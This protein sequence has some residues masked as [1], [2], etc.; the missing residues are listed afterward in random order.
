MRSAPQLLS[1]SAPSAPQLL[2]L[3][4]SQLL[5]FFTSSA[6][7]PLKP[8]SSSASQALLQEKEDERARAVRETESYKYALKGRE[9]YKQQPGWSLTNFIGS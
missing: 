8:L 1:S 7:Q 6:P 2:S 9:P 5:S 3:S 4:A